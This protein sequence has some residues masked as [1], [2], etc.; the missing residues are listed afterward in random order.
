MTR[1]VVHEVYPSKAVLDEAL[2]NGSTGAWPEQF[3][4]L[5]QVLAG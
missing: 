1:V 2:A 5:E 4:A 3:G